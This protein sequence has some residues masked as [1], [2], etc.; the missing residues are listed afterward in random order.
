MYII[1]A[2]ARNLPKSKQRCVCDPFE[3]FP[4]M[5]YHWVVSVNDSCNCLTNCSLCMYEHFV[6]V[7]FFVMTD[8]H[9]TCIYNIDMCVCA[10]A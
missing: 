9:A 3:G 7:I 6:H 1:V 5:V 8:V 4:I 2:S 10:R